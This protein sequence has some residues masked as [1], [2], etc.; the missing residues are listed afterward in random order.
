MNIKLIKNI[1]VNKKPFDKT[2]EIEFLNPKNDKKYI[3]DFYHSL[4]I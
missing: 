3:N 2:K 4:N 1:L